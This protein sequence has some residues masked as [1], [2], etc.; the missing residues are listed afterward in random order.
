MV[1]G[2]LFG[3]D[4]IP[5]ATYITASQISSA[6]PTIRYKETK[7]LTMPFGRIKDGSVALGSL[8]LIEAQ[9]AFSTISTSAGAIG[10]QSGKEVDAW[11]ALGGAAVN[12][13]SFDYVAMNPPFTRLT[14]GGG[15]SA[16]V[17]RPLFAAFGTSDADQSDMAKKAAKLLKD[18]VYHGN[19]G[20]GSAFVE[21]GHR[22]LKEKGTVGL[23]LPLS[24]L[25][26]ASW[27]K[28]RDLWRKH[29]GNVLVLSIASQEAASS[30]FS[31]DTGV[32]NA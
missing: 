25:S 14:G 22:K 21:L 10:S 27:Q 12:D 2:S 16:T 4:V 28:C 29:Y 23:I 24:T 26:G 8:D 13:Q 1:E 9:G 15:K 32:Q 6:H 30:A 20:A 5:S 17:S 11:H 31:A 7:I 3:C 18:S 19:A